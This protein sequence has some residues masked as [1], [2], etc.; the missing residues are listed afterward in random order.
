[1]PNTNYYIVEDQII[2]YKI[3]GGRKDFLTNALGSIT[4]ETDE[5][6]ELTY[7]PR[8]S[9]LGK[10]ISSNGVSSSVFGWLGALGYRETGLNVVSHY[11]RARHYSDVAGGWATTDPLWPDESAYVYVDG[12]VTNATDPSG[13]GFCQIGFCPPDVF[14]DCV[15]GC[16]THNRLFDRC[17]EKPNMPKHYTCLC[18][19]PV[20]V[21]SEAQAKSAGSGVL[22]KRL[23]PCGPGRKGKTE[24]ATSC[25]LGETGTHQTTTYSCKG[26][27]VTFSVVCCN[28]ET[29]KKT[30][31]YKITRK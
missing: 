31:F 20:P 2:S 23:G 16:K 29:G 24:P 7:Q 13:L 11:V 26:K 3:G 8:Y 19:C 4:G 12:N 6:G 28:C 14:L 17:F 25:P 5:T 27:E 22:Q 1:M 21:V 10:T 30:C 15:N 9:P 18:K